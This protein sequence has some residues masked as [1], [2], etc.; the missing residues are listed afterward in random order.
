[1]KYLLQAIKEGILQFYQMQLADEL[2][3]EI[4]SMLWILMLK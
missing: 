4:K 2:F 1:M 3:N